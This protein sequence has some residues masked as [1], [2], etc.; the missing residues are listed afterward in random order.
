VDSSRVCGGRDDTGHIS[1]KALFAVL[2]LPV[3]YSARVATKP[4]TVVTSVKSPRLFQS[5]MMGPGTKACRLHAEQG[6]A[7]LLAPGADL[8]ESGIGLDLCRIGGVHRDQ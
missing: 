8:L 2:D 6:I 1:R 7:M 4:R 5:L 3:K